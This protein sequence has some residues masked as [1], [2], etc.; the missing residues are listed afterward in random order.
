MPFGSGKYILMLLWLG[1]FIHTPAYAKPMDVHVENAGIVTLL[2]GVARSGGLNLLVDDSVTGTITLS[3][4]QKEPTEVLELI[5]AAKGLILE[6][7]GTTYLIK[8]AGEGAR[9]L[10][11]THVIPI[12]YGDPH[13]LL[14][15]VNL[16]IFNAG[17]S[18][19]T[20]N[21][22]TDGDGKGRAESAPFAERVL[23]DPGTNALLLYGTEDEAQAA[24]NLLRSLD[25]PTKQVALEAKVIAISKSAA[26][27]LGVDWSWSE[28]PQYPYTVDYTTVTRRT[29]ISP[30]VYETSRRQI[31][32]IQS[33]RTGINGSK[34][35]PG[36]VSFGRG[37]EGYPFEFYYSAKLSALITDGKAEILARPNIM[38]LQGKEAVI[39]IGGKVPVVKRETTNATV[40][41]SIDYRD[42][43]I[44][45][46]YTPRV[47][48]DGYIT[49]TVHTEVSSPVYVDAL[50]AYRF[51][52]RTADTTVRLKSGETMVIGGLI[53]SEETKSLS[54]IPFLG[55]LPLLGALFRSERKSKSESEIMIFLTANIIDDKSESIKTEALSE[56]EPQGKAAHET[57][58]GP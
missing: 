6:R 37:P 12:R 36:I 57:P 18:S 22:S 1:L 24:R 14:K 55:D 11:R 54:K 35:I 49:A 47:H 23:I 53:G 58:L 25:V 8:S 2:S 51:E 13:T 48:D 26:K 16:A 46:R 38:T 30:G 40:T 27:E 33:N 45:L 3:L 43:G 10:Y 7:R 41:N 56:R 44:I 21:K 15:T 4:S 32:E 42:A 50:E 29:E 9:S 34:H 39:N 28:L 20:E 52:E 5:A 17:I 31:P 19:S